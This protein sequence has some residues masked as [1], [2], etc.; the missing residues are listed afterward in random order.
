VKLL[1]AQLLSKTFA[2]RNIVQRFALDVHSKG[3]Q[4]DSGPVH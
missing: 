2:S 4:F 1:V 3:V